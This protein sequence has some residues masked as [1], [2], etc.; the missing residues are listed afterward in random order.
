MCYETWN[1]LVAKLV[2]SECTVVCVSRGSNWVNV[3][4]LKQ[5][6]PLNFSRLCAS[7]K[8]LRDVPDVT[9]RI[10][11]VRWYVI[12]CWWK[13]LSSLATQ[14]SYVPENTRTNSGCYIYSYVCLVRSSCR[15]LCVSGGFCCSS[16]NFFTW[17]MKNEGFEQDQRTKWCVSDARVLLALV[18]EP[19]VWL[20]VKW[21]RLWQ[22]PKVFKIYHFH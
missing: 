15:G 14:H 13:W 17:G 10:G 21:L 22:I 3:A 4:W 18:F 20:T 9:G 11:R 5:Q 7:P 12:E 19:P 16:C 1:P 6:S 2:Y 8:W